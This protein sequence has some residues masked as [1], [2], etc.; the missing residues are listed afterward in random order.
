M[1]QQ[2]G[3][4]NSICHD[5]TGHRKTASE[6]TKVTVHPV[7]KWGL[8]TTDKCPCGNKQTRYHILSSR[9]GT[10]LESGLQRRDITRLVSLGG[11][12]SPPPPNEAAAPKTKTG[13]R[14]FSMPV[15]CLL[16]PVTA[17]PLL[18]QINTPQVFTTTVTRTMAQG[19]RVSY[20]VLD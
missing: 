9:Q 4:Q 2:C 18:T 1:T 3:N 7:K 8:T 20:S 6:L 17:S 13:I 11:L 16:S 19:T 15:C 5:V 14:L 10:K 12:K